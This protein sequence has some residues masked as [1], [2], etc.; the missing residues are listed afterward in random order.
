MALRKVI[1]D[2]SSIILL[3]KVD[4]FEQFCGQFS[5]IITRQVYTELMDGAKKG[6]ARLQKYLHD[7]I[8]QSLTSRITFGMGQG[9]SSVI[10]LY[11]EGGG[12]FVLLDD[13][14]GANYCKD[15]SIPFINSLLA[16]RVLYIA[17]AIGEAEFTATTRQL[18]EEG[19]YSQWII[20]KAESISNKKL[21][22]FLP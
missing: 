6:S 1:A 20:D 3:Q 9:E 4:L 21:Q 8:D 10:A 14:K 13:K 19:Y 2:S 16:S 22:Q 15:H 18:T 12:D 17:G 11:L 5:V 7:R